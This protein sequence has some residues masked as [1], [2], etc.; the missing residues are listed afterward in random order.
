MRLSLLLI[1]AIVLIVFG[2]IAAAGSS[3]LLFSTQAIIWFMASF[4]AYLADIAVGGW[5][6][7][8]ARQGAPPA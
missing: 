4:L 3:G 6:P 7:W 8:T 1:A 2:I 5:A